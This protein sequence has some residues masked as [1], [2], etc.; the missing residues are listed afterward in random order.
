ML[1]SPHYGERWGRP[2]LAAAGYSEIRGR[3]VGGKTVFLAEGIWQYRDYVIQFWNQDKPHNHFL[4]EQLAG[5]EM[6]QW[7]DAETFTPEMKQ[8]LIATGFL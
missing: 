4:T 1:G 6:I 3:G 7:R 8:M 2:W 5:D